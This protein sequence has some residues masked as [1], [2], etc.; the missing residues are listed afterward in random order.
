M[1]DDAEWRE[2]GPR[3]GLLLVVTP[4]RPVGDGSLAGGLLIVCWLL[5][6]LANC[7]RAAWGV[8]L[9]L[10]VGLEWFVGTDAGLLES[11]DG[12]MRSCTHRLHMCSSTGRGQ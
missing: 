6:A 5:L 7:R 3:G 4:G 10:V 8:E 12:L 1:G 9:M 11:R 2:G